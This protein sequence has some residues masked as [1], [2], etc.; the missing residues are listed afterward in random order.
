[1]HILK[2]LFSKS[3][4]QKLNSEYT[5]AFCDKFASEQKLKQDIRD[6]LLKDFKRQV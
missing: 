3:H 2:Y 4:R 1:M 6:S 5:K